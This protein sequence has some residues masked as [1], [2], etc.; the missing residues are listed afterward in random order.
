MH[1]RL[2]IKSNQFW[3]QIILYLISDL[4][5]LQSNQHFGLQEKRRRRSRRGKLE[6]WS[7]N[8]LRW[9]ISQLKRTCLLK[10]MFLSFLHINLSHQPKSL[11]ILKKF[12]LQKSNNEGTN[13]P[14]VFRLGNSC[15]NETWK[16]SVLC[17]SFRSQKC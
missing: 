14:P 8:G 7:R 6:L 15:K 4:E 3:T 13:N 11:L 16:E 12:F 17:N 5:S 9:T 1:K 10:M 2:E